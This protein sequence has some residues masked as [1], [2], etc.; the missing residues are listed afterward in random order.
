MIVVGLIS[1]TSADGIDAAVVRIDGRPPALDW[2]LLA[3]RTV[4]Y[5]DE[6]RADVLAC[7]DPATGNVEL[8]CRLNFALGQAFAAAAL[9]AIALAG[10]TSE[11]VDLIGS[12]G[13]TVWHIPNGA[14]A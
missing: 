1:G 5:S 7:C 10:L 8:V 12:H 4:P 13:Q 11:Q 6:L 9:Q 14:A 2:Q 3:H